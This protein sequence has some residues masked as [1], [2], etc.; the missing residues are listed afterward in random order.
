M[1]NHFKSRWLHLSGKKRRAINTKTTK[2]EIK[3]T[4]AQKRAPF[5]RAKKSRRG[6]ISSVCANR[7]ASTSQTL[8]IKS[9][10]RFNS[11]IA[12]LTNSKPCLLFCFNAP[13]SILRLPSATMITIPIVLLSQQLPYVHVPTFPHRRC[14]HYSRFTHRRWALVEPST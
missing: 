8:P 14:F 2:I 6:R 10:Q 12:S 4:I 7:K 5:S 11:R 1:I 9:S 3:V 13:P